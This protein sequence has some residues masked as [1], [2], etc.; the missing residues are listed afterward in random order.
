VPA[1]NLLRLSGPQ[2]GNLRDL[3]IAAFLPANFG[4]L[5]VTRVDR[6]IFNYASLNDPYPIQ[7]L[8]VL[9]AANGELWWRELLREARN[10][11]PADPGLL[12]FAAAVGQGPVLADGQA[13]PLPQAERD[14]ELRIKASQSTFDIL[15]WRRR[16]GEIES[17]VC[18]IELPEGQPRATGFLIGPDLVITNY[19]VVQSLTAPGSADMA[20][21][22]LRF[23]Y[24]VL[25]DGISV[26]AGKT[27]GLAA[28]NWLA[29]A[30]PFSQRDLEAAPATDPSADEL[31]YA[32]LRVDGRPGDD[33]VG[34]DTQS[35][36]PVKRGWIGLPPLPHD[37]LQQP[38]L[39]IVQHPDGKP[40]QVAVDSQAVI[41]V[42][43]NRTR[44]R[45][46]TTTEPGSSGSPCFSANWE[47]VALH[48]S[49]DPKWLQGQKP[50]Y[51]QGI[52]TPAIVT[53]LQQRG[54]SALLIPAS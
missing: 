22:K 33:P 53:L 9:M 17:R 42:N 47:W 1:L 13:Q 40:M 30:S 10:A 29:D 31:D 7:V 11:R 18:R 20:R 16:L 46:T 41:G 4:D 12:A 21:L 45:Y 37:F 28:P 48:H 23:D 5:M 36:F 19:H 25:E 26:G 49:G 8:N 27:Y 50:E 35:A 54:R 43:A 3:L 24:K 38:A 6:P 44:V 34:G 32:I 14:L 2:I 52:P 39:Y 51:N 15:T